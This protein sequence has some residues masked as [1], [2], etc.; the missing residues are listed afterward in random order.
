[1]AQNPFFETWTTPFG[2]PPFDRIVTAHFMPAFERTIVTHR[3]EIDALRD[4]PQAPT[5]ANTIE[6]LE[7]AGMDLL[8]VN[9][10]F[11]NLT[12]TESDD[13]LRQVERDISPILAR[14]RSAIYLDSKIL[15][16][17]EAVMNGPEFASLN[18][19]QKRLTERIHKG[20]VRAG[21]RLTDIERAR[22][23][24]IT[25]RLATLGTQFAQNVLKDES[26]YV[27]WLET[28][29]D[30]AGLPEDFRQAAA[31]LATARGKPGGHAVSLSRGNVEAFLI[32]STRA[33]L[34][35]TLLNAF[36]ARG[37]NGG[38]SDNRAIIAETIALRDERARLLGYESYAHYKLDDTMAETPDAVR[39]LLD[40]VWAP[41]RTAAARERDRLAEMASQEGQ[42]GPIRKADWRHYAEKIRHADY[43]IDDA[44][45]RPYF[46]L[47]RMIDAAFHVAQKLF[48]L[49]FEERKDLPLY[50][51]DVRA[52]EVKDS[53]GKHVALFLGDYFARPSKR[54]GAWMSAFRVQQNLDGVVRP[55][56]I[57]VL[58]IAKPAGGEEALL[59]IDEARTLFHEFGHALHGMLS[60]VTY[61]A[62]S[63]TS[64][65][66]DFVEL[67]SQLYEHW[68]MQPQV[69]RQYARHVETGEPIPD[70]LI[71]RLKAARG[72]N[73]GFATVEYCASA[74]VD[75]DMH[76]A[77]Q[78]ATADPLAFERGVLAKIDMPDEIAMRHRSPHFTHVYSGEGYASGYYSYL[79][80]EVLDADAFSA[81]EEKG[82]IFDPETAKRLRDYIYAAGNLRDPKEAYLAFRGK[83]QGVDA[84]LE[85]RGLA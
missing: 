54:S 85:K 83:L 19:E 17:I 48:G 58:N 26:D 24:E 2:I 66:T 38:E 61:P 55:I 13:A 73:Q 41:A 39:G 52:Y 45:L 71:A 31:A 8:R 50:S 3:A 53:A 37:E 51:P 12:G 80:S 30:L 16:R 21:A 46:P 63:G 22:L 40:R 49:S 60:D 70:D 36:L 43:A 62:L 18:A 67:P 57:N 5:F 82:D 10:V 65:S 47:S 76:L 79:W 20:F 1:M 75:L 81:F 68:L 25:A 56:I 11:R 34:R 64:V 72:F 69:L 32:H 84:L 29:A 15:A 6:D 28:E 33:D 4:N 7:R 78:A 44:E 77:A 23:T 27:L 14:H 59:S 9:L 74:F 35:E 42:N